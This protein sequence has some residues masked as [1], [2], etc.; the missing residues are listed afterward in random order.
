[1]ANMNGF[2]ASQVAPATPYEP[3]PAGDYLAIIV[4]SAMETSKDGGSE[5][6]KLKLEVIDGP[7]KG[8]ILFDRILRKHANRKAVEIGSA[9][10]SS[11]CH[12]VNVL[13]PNDSQQLHNLP[14]LAS[15]KCAK[16]KDTGEISN[17]IK[18]YKSKNA[19]AP[20]SHQAPTA[21]AGGKAPW[22]R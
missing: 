13:R 10:L 6:L 21:V 18:V 17:E 22:A 15:V 19:A 7:C 1:M 5:F 9:R 20:A 4:E 3:L 11:L 16:R 14:V 2:D 8:R 12:A